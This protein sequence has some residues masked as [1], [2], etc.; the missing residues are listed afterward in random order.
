MSM[1]SAFIQNL[2]DSR[3]LASMLYSRMI[4]MRSIAR[5]QAPQI[6]N[7]PEYQWLLGRDILYLMGALNYTQNNIFAANGYT[8]TTILGYSFCSMDNGTLRLLKIDSIPSHMRYTY[9]WTESA[10]HRR[11]PSAHGGMNPERI[12]YTIIN[13]CFPHHY[14]SH[15]LIHDDVRMTS[16]YEYEHTD[17]YEVMVCRA[18]DVVT[19]PWT[20]TVTIS[21]P[22]HILERG[23]YARGMEKVAKLAVG[24][25][26]T[27]VGL[28]TYNKDKDC[29]EWQVEVSFV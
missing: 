15:R 8:A 1:L 9:R 14:H 25:A 22:G 20:R 12:R 17:T 21:Q 3:I 7:V 11:H 18:E 4:E 29:T 23:V 19:G 16:Q 24:G 2:E 5:L 10:F 28:S 13:A 6:I 27:K 26:T